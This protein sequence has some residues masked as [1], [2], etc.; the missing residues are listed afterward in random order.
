MQNLDITKAPIM[1]AFLFLIG[2]NKIEK[3][4]IFLNHST[5]NKDI[6]TVFIFVHKFLFFFNISFFR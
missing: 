1:G 5:V 2:S 4:L 3:S 6:F